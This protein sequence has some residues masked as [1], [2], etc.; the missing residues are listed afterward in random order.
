MVISRD[1]PPWRPAW[2]MDNLA[3]S[4]S[5]VDTR[6]LVLSEESEESDASFESDDYEDCNSPG[7]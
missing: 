4:T 3:N 5:A 7:H 2:P 6:Q 1:L